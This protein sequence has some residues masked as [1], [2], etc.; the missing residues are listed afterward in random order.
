MRVD[1]CVSSWF[2]IKNSL[3]LAVPWSTWSVPSPHS[4][5]SRLGGAVGGRAVRR[6]PCVGET[7][8][9]VRS[10]G[11]IGFVLL[12]TKALSKKKELKFHSSLPPLGCLFS[13]FSFFLFG[14]TRART[15]ADWHTHRLTLPP[16][17][18]VKTLG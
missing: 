9:K 11:T 1:W 15:G 8:T 4:S 5:L 2:R 16:R 14:T 18:C 17:G 7:A 6:G 13:F 3:S 12:T 10:Q